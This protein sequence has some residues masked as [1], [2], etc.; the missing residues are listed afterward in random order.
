MV[1]EYVPVDRAAAAAQGLAVAAM[2]L[3]APTNLST[4][5]V[6]LRSPFGADIDEVAAQ[7]AVIGL[8]AGVQSHSVSPIVRSPPDSRDVS[9]DR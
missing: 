5:C 7:D 9:V 2:R 3:R 4:R 6:R 8:A 1:D